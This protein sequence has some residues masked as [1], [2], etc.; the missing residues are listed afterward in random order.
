MQ[1]RSFLVSGRVQGV[2]YRA[3]A[4]KHAMFLG[5]SGYARNLPD[6]S[7]EVFVGGDRTAL[8]T[9]SGLLHQGPSWS[10]VRH[11]EEREAAPAGYD[12]FLIR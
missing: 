2:G 5:L 1:Y 10:E 7:V 4:R 11:V 6:G 12:G 8:D 9:L 3:F